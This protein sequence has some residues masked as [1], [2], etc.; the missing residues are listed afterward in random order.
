MTRELKYIIY[1][2][3]NRIGKFKIPCGYNHYEFSRDNGLSYND[4]IEIGLI[5]DG[6]VII[7]ECKD[8]KHRQKRIDKTSIDKNTYRAREIESLYL[9]GYTKQG[10]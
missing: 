7:L 6:Q 5:V 10:D 4:I 8:L 1:K 3:Y 2:R 9:Y